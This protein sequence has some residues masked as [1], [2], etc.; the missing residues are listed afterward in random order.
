MTVGPLFPALHDPPERTALAFPDATLSY[1]RL[2]AVAGALAGELA[3]LERVALWAA[4]SIHTGVGM[5]SAALAGVLAVPLNRSAGERELEHAVRDSDPQLVIAPPDAELPDVLASRPRAAAD[6]AAEGP[7]PAEPRD[8]EAPALLVYTSGT[9]GPPKG[10]VLP[11][12]AIASNLDAIAAA[13][14]WTERDEV[15]HALPLFHVHGL[16]LGTLGPLRRGGTSRHLGRFD[17]AAVAGALTSGATMLFGVPTMY[18]RLADAA[19]ADAEI[20]DA[21]RRARLLVSGSAALRAEEHA[22]IERLTGQRIVERYGMSETL[23]TISIRASGDRR[24]GYVGQPVDGVDVRLVDESGEPFEGDD[25]ETVGEL[26]VRGPNLFLGYYGNP[27]ATAEAMRGGWFRTGDLATRA[28]DGSI[29]IVGRKSTDLI[30]SGGFKIG[31]GEVESA[32]LEHP[33]VKEAAVLGSPDADLG[34]VVV[35]WVVLGDGATASAAELAEHVER[36]LSRHKRPRVVEFVD[37]LP[38]NALG[39]VQKA[40]LPLPAAPPA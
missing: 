11:R 2:A 29:R 40:C 23:M 19:E 10:A 5:V 14:D 22:R 18:G 38:R 28:S 15:V 33:A 39:K 24:P 7:L 31:A 27:G 12:R 30:K 25:D 37:S 21:L 32:L 1:E 3:G 20:A 34:E 26:E 8:P 36:L 17:P 6:L 13:W 16:V 9:T 4:P 35:A